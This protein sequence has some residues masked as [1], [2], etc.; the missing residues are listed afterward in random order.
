VEAALETVRP[1][2]VARQVTLEMSLDPEAVVQGDPSRLQQ[3]AWNL[4]TNAV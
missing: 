4:L 3:I 2:A 1:S